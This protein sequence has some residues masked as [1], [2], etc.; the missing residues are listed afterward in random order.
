MW[1][2]IPLKSLYN[3]EVEFGPQASVSYLQTENIP[4]W[5]PT[6]QMR[7]LG[8]ESFERS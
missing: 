7:A 3:I 6:S 5:V 2:L 8:Y 4:E 1:Y